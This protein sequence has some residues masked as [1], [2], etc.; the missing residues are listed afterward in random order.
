M[1]IPEDEELH[2]RLGDLWFAQNNFPGAI[3]E[4]NAVIA[5]NPLDKASAQFNLARAYFAAG[6]KDQAEEHLLASLEARARLSARS[7]IAAA[8]EGFQRREIRRTK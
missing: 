4:Y 8:N 5:L 1:S 3:R 6:Q 2:R 7:K